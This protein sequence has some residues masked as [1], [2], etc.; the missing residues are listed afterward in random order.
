M[1]RSLHLDP[2]DLKVESKTLT[3]VEL[4]AQ[5]V[6]KNGAAL[7]LNTIG[8]QRRV[9][10]LTALSRRYQLVRENGAALHL[11]LCKRFVGNEAATLRSLSGVFS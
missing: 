4:A 7:H 3:T 5:A 1:E 6:E 2:M 11:N 10:Q 8:L 9:K